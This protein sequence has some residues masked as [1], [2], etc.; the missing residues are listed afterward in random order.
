VGPASPTPSYR[1]HVAGHL[2]DHWSDWLGGHPL[3]RN[4]DGTTTLTVEGADQAQLH[5]VL[6]GIRDLGVTL[7]SLHVVDPA[8]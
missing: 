3:V 6:S 8:S 4:S 2:D 7:L 5:G 1:L